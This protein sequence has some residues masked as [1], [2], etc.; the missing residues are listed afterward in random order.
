MSAIYTCGNCSGVISKSTSVCPH[1]G[2]SLAGIQCAKCHFTGTASDFV[3]DRCPKCG[4]RIQVESTKTRDRIR[5]RFSPIV[6]RP[7][8][9]RGA[10]A[11]A[12][13]SITTVIVIS[14]S[15]EALLVSFV[16]QLAI[17]FIIF[18]ALFTVLKALFS[19]K[20]KNIAH[21]KENT[22]G[23]FEAFKD[24][25]AP[26]VNNR[27]TGIILLLIIASIIALPILGLMFNRQ[28]DM[29]DL[30]FGLVVNI[31][32]GLILALFVSDSP[33]KQIN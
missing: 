24:L 14:I 16:W 11:G 6:N 9:I 19:E 32:A 15:S 30:V 28:I 1:C 8:V 3:N 17:T 31:L 2:V 10:S 22:Y 26:L 20:I 18:S 21:S 23:A 12:T 4:T 27:R 25:L 5:S 29:F 13:I 33:K 7:T